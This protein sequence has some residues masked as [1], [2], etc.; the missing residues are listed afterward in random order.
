MKKPPAQPF[1]FSKFSGSGNDF[2]IIDHRDRWCADPAELARLACRRGLSIGADGIILLE[3][4][5]EPAREN[6]GPPAHFAMRIINADGSE[7]DMCGNGARCV[8]RYAFLEK[9]APAE[10]LITTGAGPVA[11]RVFPDET[12]KISLSYPVHLA[13]DQVVYLGRET[14]R[15]DCLNTGVPH[16][17]IVVEDL[18]AVDVDGLGRTVRHHEQFKPAGTNVNFARRLTADTIAVRT[19]ERGVEAETLACGTG[20]VASA[21]ALAIRHEMLPPVTVVTRGGER[22]VVHFQLTPQGVGDLF[23]Q[24]SARL[25]Y[26]GEAVDYL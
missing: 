16:A 11:A 20:S 25:V 10:M 18:E 2:I 19:Y 9:I 26:R 22:L 6:A 4:A 12:V 5:P 1:R 17:V 15:V 3:P 8:A 23:L 24:G 13:L 7:A 21:I 14:L